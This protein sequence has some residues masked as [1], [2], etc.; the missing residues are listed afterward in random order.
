MDEFANVWVRNI[1][2]TAK[3][4]EEV[5]MCVCVCVCVCVCA[6]VCVCLF[7][8]CNC[9][10]VWFRRSPSVYLLAGVLSKQSYVVTV[11]VFKKKK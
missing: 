8:V 4:L 6:C 5:G 10:C 2:Y 3:R 1:V 9:M 11:C 7:I